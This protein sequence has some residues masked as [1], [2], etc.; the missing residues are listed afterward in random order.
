MDARGISPLALRWSRCFKSAEE[1]SSVPLSLIAS[2]RTT[3]GSQSPERL[4]FIVSI[5]ARSILS[6]SAPSLSALLMA[7]TSADSRIP[8]FMV[9]ISSPAPGA[10]TSRVVSAALTM[11]IST[12]PDPTVST[13]IMSLPMA[14]MTC[15]APMAALASPP[16]QPRVARERI[17]TLGSALWRCILILSPSKAPPVSALVGSMAITPTLMSCLRK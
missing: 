13:R 8:A 10:K 5:V 9:W 7:I 3:G 6:W 1:S 14:S 11:S 15:T 4:A 16:T 2:V 12:C 17:N